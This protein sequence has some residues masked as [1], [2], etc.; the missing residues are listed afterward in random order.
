M[1]YEGEAC[2]GEWRGMHPSVDVSWFGLGEVFFLLERCCGDGNL[3][4]LWEFINESTGVKGREDDGG[5]GANL[6][7]VSIL[8]F[9]TWILVLNF[10]RVISPVTLSIIRTHS[11]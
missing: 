6:W 1:G 10:S 5:G 9:L 2:K 11:L 3:F 8:V 4:L 7:I